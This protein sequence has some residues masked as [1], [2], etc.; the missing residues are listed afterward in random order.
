MS[1]NSQKA[2]REDREAARRAVYNARGRGSCPFEAGTR[3]ARL[4]AK[5]TASY[6]RAEARF[7]ELALAYGEFRPDRLAAAEAP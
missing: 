1:R 5:E 3:R 2:Y 7:D 4:W 6:N